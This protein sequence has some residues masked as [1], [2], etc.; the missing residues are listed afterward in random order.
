MPQTKPAIDSIHASTWFDLLLLNDCEPD[1][2]LDDITRDAAQ[3][4]KVP[5]AMINLVTADEII[6]K[7]C[8]GEVQ[9]NKIE[10]SGAFCSLAV[11]SEK[12]LMIPDARLD[13]RFKNF[14]MVTGPTAIRAYLGKALHS[15]DGSI[16]GTFCLFDTRPRR[17]TAKELD[18]LDDFVEMAETQLATIFTSL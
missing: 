12:P 9:G 15:P 3:L 18:L 4:F 1:E 16:I 8:V 11:N 13:P 2:K 17:F 10:R 7:A 5:I 6:F 14:F